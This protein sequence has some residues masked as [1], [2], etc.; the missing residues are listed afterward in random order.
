MGDLRGLMRS[1]SHCDPISRSDA[2]PAAL[3]RALGPLRRNSFNKAYANGPR[4]RQYAR[5]REAGRREE[6]PLFGARPLATAAQRS[7]CVCRASP[8]TDGQAMHSSAPASRT[9]LTGVC[10]R[11]Q[12]SL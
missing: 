2:S 12:S 11:L 9:R 1:V 6:R 4:Q 10:R 3:L 7:M 5:E 8:A